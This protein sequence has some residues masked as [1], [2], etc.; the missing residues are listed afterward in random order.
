[1]RRRDPEQLTN[2]RGLYVDELVV[3]LD[4]APAGWPATVTTMQS[5]LLKT[6]PKSKFHPVP[7]SWQELAGYS[8]QRKME[9]CA[10]VWRQWVHNLVS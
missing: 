8:L 5:A 4:S 9:A 3:N 10:K 6:L 7:Q 1:M 2:F